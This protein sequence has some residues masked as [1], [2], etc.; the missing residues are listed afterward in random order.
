M[1]TLEAT[2]FAQQEPSASPR[3]TAAPATA[4]PTPPFDSGMHP[5]S[6][7]A[8]AWI[9]NLRRTAYIGRSGH[10]V[11]FG[12]ALTTMLKYTQRQ[13]IDAYEPGIVR[14]AK[15]GLLKICFVHAPCGSNESYA[16]V[17]RAAD[18]PAPPASV[19]GAIDDPT[20]GMTLPALLASFRRDPN[21][22]GKNVAKDATGAVYL[23]TSRDQDP[24]PS[25]YDH[26][27]LATFD[28]DYIVRDGIVVA[29]VGVASEN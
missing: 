22:V 3:A 23:V 11:L 27:S 14:D 18:V 2:A 15:R 1:G 25:R 17:V 9:A 26:G 24:P 5:S 12:S 10:R 4:S 29:H 6:D 13:P 20:I 16:A 19:E 28:N 21:F 8:R 7:A